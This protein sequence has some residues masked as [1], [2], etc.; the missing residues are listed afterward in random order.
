MQHCLQDQQILLCVIVTD[1]PVGC[2]LVAAPSAPAP[3]CA[4]PK[5]PLVEKTARPRVTRQ[6]AEPCRPAW[7][8]EGAAQAPSMLSS[9]GAPRLC[10]LSTMCCSGHT[11][12]LC[13]GHAKLLM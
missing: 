5:A 10:H 8:R 3:R 7:Q 2:T 1:S 6:S 4:L 12:S 11:P 13:R 9:C